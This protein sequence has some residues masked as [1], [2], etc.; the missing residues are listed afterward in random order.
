M[1][2]RLSSHST[3]DDASKY[4]AADELAALGVAARHP[5]ARLKAYLQERGHWDDDLEET[6]RGDA[7]AA[8]RAALDG[9]EAKARPARATLFDDVYHELTPELARQKRALDA[10]AAE[11]EA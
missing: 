4:R 3:S 7:R 8:A 6:T 11:A 5:V 10:H 9:A 2:Y 1:T